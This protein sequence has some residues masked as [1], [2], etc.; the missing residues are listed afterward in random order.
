M[1]K[2]FFQKYSK[3]VQWIVVLAICIF[4]LGIYQLSRDKKKA[5]SMNTAETFIQAQKKLGKKPNRLI[6]EK[7]PYLLQHAFNPVDW[8]PWGEEAFEKARREGNP[9]F[10]SVGYSTC[11]W[12]HVMEREVFENSEI[13]AL[14]NKYFVNIKV[15]REERPDVDRVYMAA[16]LEMTGSG[17]WPMSLFLTP[18]LK[19][20]FG[21]TYIPPVSQYGRM[22]F[23]DLAKRIHELWQTQRDK[24]LQSSEEITGFLKQ[25]GAVDTSFAVGEEVLKNGFA[26]FLQQYD[27]VYGGF[28]EAPKFP[29]PVTFN[30]LV[31]YYARTGDGSAL[32]MTLTTLRKMAEGGI[33]DHLGGGF[34]RYS[35][36]GQWRVPH[37][38]KMLYDQAQLVNSY[39]DAYQVTHEQFYASIARDVLEYVL[40]QMTHKTGGFYSAEDAESALDPE[41]PEEKAEGEFYLWRKKQIENIL[42]KEQANIFNYYYGV[43]EHGNTLSDPHGVLGDKNVLY[44]DHTL[45]E[46]ATKFDM[47]V[48]EIDKIL[49]AA[50]KKLFDVRQKRPHPHL[51]DKILTSWNGLMISAFAR[52]YQLL[53][54]QRYLEAA[55]RAAQFITTQLYDPSK[56]QLLHRF[57]D[58]EARFDAHLEDYA[59]LIMGL[60]DLYEASFEISWLEKA[61]LLTKQQNEIFYD[62][63]D[64]GFWSTSGK[65]KS[66][67]VRMKEDY[68]GAEPTANSLAV[69]NLL[70][71]SQITDNRQWREMAE[72]TLEY[73]GGRLKQIPH[74]IPQMLVAVDFH[75]TKPKEIIIAG[76][77]LGA[78]TKALVRQVH[79]RFM[80]N[81][82][83]LLADGGSGQ[84]AL[85]SY[86]TFLE[87]ISMRDGKATAYVCE[88][89][90]CKLPATD[91]RI[92]AQQLEGKGNNIK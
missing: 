26:Q 46:T 64:G 42:G 18:D 10:L 63:K 87:N 60:L 48:E 38:E 2:M 7:S 79:Q 4:T 15:D 92:L 55:R 67:L 56:K 86:N 28:G 80:P 88:N 83:L 1:N 41:K 22:G 90:V 65:D 3:Y 45:V 9:I 74:A 25:S 50:R 24:I 44:I 49:T 43:E 66:I 16:V 51:D 8:Y 35:V 85:A 75:L 52:A 11:Y 37:F 34:H 20:F 13:A 70:R 19:P 69:L 58:G 36:D 39:L 53:D 71:L 32:Q 84:R 27:S 82:I 14:M 57:R 76:S 78:D 33:Y 40:R 6:H 59:F 91:T 12:C 89:Y 23:P 30:F 54:D 47:H 72:K 31:H 5:N 17:G 73:F 68:D 77:P 81:K 61:I 29:R 21:G 62:V